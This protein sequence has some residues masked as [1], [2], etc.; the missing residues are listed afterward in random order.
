MDNTKRRKIEENV[1]FEIRII[2]FILLIL[3]TQRL[4]VPAM[5]GVPVNIILLLVVLQVLIEPFSHMARWAFYGGL[6]LDVLGG[7][8]LGWHSAQLLVAMMVVYLLLARVTSE[9]WVLPVVAVF[10]GGVAYHAVNIVFMRLLISE[11]VIPEYGVV[12]LIPELLVL[13]VP[14]LPVFLLLRWL[15]S[16]RRGEVPID[17]Y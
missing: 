12:V 9:K 6:M 10:I 11:F 5:F 7:T 17:V 16:M 14:A 2:G 13:L 4:F 15:R 3:L 1:W 8:W